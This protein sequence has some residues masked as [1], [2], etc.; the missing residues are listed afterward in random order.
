MSTPKLSIKDVNL[1]YGDFHALHG[2]SMDIDENKITSFIGPSGCGG[3][4]KIRLS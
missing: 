4:V 2:I 1:F 3:H